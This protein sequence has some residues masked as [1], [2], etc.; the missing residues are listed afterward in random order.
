MLVIFQKFF[1]NNKK[2]TE[3]YP[4]TLGS[5][6]AAYRKKRYGKALCDDCAKALAEAKAGA[7]E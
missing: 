2:R 5:Q 4:M 7:A 1:Y 6:I 3:E